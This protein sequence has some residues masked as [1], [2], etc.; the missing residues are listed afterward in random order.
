MNGIYH[1]KYRFFPASE[2]V[3]RGWLRRQLEIQAA[4]LSGHLH[5]VWPDVRDSAWIGGKAEGWERVPYWLDGFIPLAYLLR[6]E[7]LIATA[8]RY[9][10]AILTAQEADGW[11]C[12]CKKEERAHYD[13][14]AV[15]LICKVL[16]VYH[17]CSGDDRARIATYRALKILSDHIRSNTLFNWGQS[18]WFEAILPLQWLYEQLPEP[19]MEELAITLS[20]QGFSYR[21]VFDH[22]YDQEPDPRGIWRQQTHIV[23]LMMALKCEAVVSGLTGDNPDAFA[24]EMYAKLLEY[25]GTPIG[26]IQGDECLTGKSPIQGTELCAIVEAMYSCEILAS[27]T[28][29]PFWLDLLEQLSFNSLPATVSSDMWTHQYDQLLNQISCSIQQEPPVYR[30]NGTQSNLFGLEPNYGCCTA[31]FSQGWPKL[32]WTSFLRTENGILSAVLVPS[33]VRTRIRD[34]EVAVALDTAYPFR[35]TLRYTIRSAGNVPFEFAVRIPGFV[36]AAYVNGR[37]IQP[38][39][40]WREERV[41]Q[42][43]ET[44]EVKLEMRPEW[45]T[46]FGNLRC[47]RRGPLFFALPVAEKAE[48]WEYVR[49]GV[50][51]KAP[52][53][54]YQIMPVGEWRYGFV[55]EEAEIVENEIADEPFSREHPPVQLKVGMT[56]VQWDCFPGQPGVC[57]ELPGERIESRTETLS[58]QPYGCTTLRMTL[59]P[60]Y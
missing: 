14:W 49:D 11:I 4:G 46:G 17:R 1:S 32:A 3:P 51:R 40:I 8:K 34:R 38:G 60:F 27:V 59:M 57:A 13:V 43:G 47:L 37:A 5:E 15:F 39:A 31:N 45:I 44:V 53:C 2:L 18:R 23:N 35:D 41:W 22:W 25:H 24:S 12:P 58:L 55:G 52:Y 10:D 29:R 54:D 28:G 56:R 19:W 7:K 48:P 16:M 30:T 42:D 36:H 50:E 26:H 21:R 6:D 9:M 33:E 20:A